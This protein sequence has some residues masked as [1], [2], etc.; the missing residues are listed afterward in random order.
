MHE[1]CGFRRAAFIGKD[2]LKQVC[3]HLTQVCSHVTHFPK[4]PMSHL[5]SLSGI[6]S[7]RRI[8]FLFLSHRR[9]LFLFL[10]DHRIL[11]RILSGSIKKA[12]LHNKE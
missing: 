1:L 10:S 3:S 2:H 7:D 4:I 11:S 5:T 9:I 12:I 6:L 8:L